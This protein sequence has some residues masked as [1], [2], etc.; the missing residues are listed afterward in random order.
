[1]DPGLLAEFSKLGIIGILFFLTIMALKS[2]DA[3]YRDVQEKRIQENRE[4][5]ER[6]LAA[7]NANTEAT[8]AGSEAIKALAKAFEDTRYQRGRR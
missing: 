2:R 7:T 6:F 5:T 4:N 8:K 3:S 1:M